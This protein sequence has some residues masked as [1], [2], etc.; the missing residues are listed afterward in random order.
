MENINKTISETTSRLCSMFILSN[1][2]LMMMMIIMVMMMM[3]M[4]M[5]MMIQ[6]TKKGKQFT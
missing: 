2:N 4:M 3:M 5:M 6:L 1:Y